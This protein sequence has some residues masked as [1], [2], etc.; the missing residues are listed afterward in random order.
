MNNIFLITLLIGSLIG[1]GIFSFAAMGD[2]SMMDGWD[3]SSGHHG[4]M[5]DDDHHMEGSEHHEECE[6]YMDEHCEYED[7]EDCEAYSDECD[8]HDEEY[9]EHHENYEKVQQNSYPT[10]KTV[11]NENIKDISITPAI[12]Q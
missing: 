10:I 2:G 11:F 12:D 1:G 4:M 5:H 9:C 3:W 7:S 8:E 6:E